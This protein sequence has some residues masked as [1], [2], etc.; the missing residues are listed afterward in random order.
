[1]SKLFFNNTNGCVALRNKKKKRCYKQT[2]SIK[3]N[4]TK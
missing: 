1:M 3:S 4:R 2:R